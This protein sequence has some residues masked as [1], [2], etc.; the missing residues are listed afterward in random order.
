V[1]GVI[2]CAWEGEGKL[3]C[4]GCRIA[5]ISLIL[6]RRTAET[7]PGGAADPPLGLVMEPGHALGA[8]ETESVALQ[9]LFRVLKRSLP[10]LGQGRGDPF[11]TGRAA[12]SETSPW[13]DVGV[14]F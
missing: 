11:V 14:A 1:G 12:M 2:Y 9:D 7:S 3:C 8:P 5:S 10:W 6:E 4:C 13:H